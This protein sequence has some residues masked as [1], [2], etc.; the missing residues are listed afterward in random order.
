MMEDSDG[1]TNGDDDAEV[2]PE[3]SKTSN[4][5]DIK[6]EP[7]GDHQEESDPVVHEIPVF[8]AKG[9][10]QLYLFQYP[11]RPAHMPYDGVEVTRAKI[12]PNNKQVEMEL[13]IN[14]SNPNYDRSKGEQIALNVDG[15]ANG[16]VNGSASENKPKVFQSSVMD[17][18]LLV[19]SSAV[20]RTGRYAVGLLDDNEL[21]LTRLDGVLSLRPSL[22]YLDKGDNRAKEK[23]RTA[24]NQEDTE[25]SLEEKP[26]AVTVKFARGDPERN[27]KYK[28]KSYEYQK[29]M[30]EEEAWVETRFNQMKGNLWDSESQL[31]FCSS[32]DGDV[33]DMDMA[34]KQYLLSL[35]DGE[36][37]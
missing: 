19:G 21:H 16:V 11:V 33:R 8:L 13:Q 1:R 17:K 27:K 9:I 31:M 20:S 29:K 6:M 10:Q 7:E 3:P 25:D 24:A 35:K 4:P 22:S 28:E 36:G 14:T 26:E 30:Q 15:P 18:Q 23:D 2:E 5:D 32:M 37:S 34:P 12:R